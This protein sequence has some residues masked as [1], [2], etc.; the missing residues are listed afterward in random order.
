MATPPTPRTVTVGIDGNEQNP[1][2]FPDSILWKPGIGEKT[3]RIKV[4]KKVHR[5]HKGDYRLEKYP[6]TCV[7]ERKHGIRELHTNLLTPDRTR[8]MAAFRRFSTVDKPV[9]MLEG[10]LQEFWSTKEIW[11]GSPPTKV[12]VDPAEVWGELMKVCR[13]FNFS[14]WFAG[15]AD[16][17]RSRQVLGEAALRMML[18]FA[19][20]PGG[21]Q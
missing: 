18:T 20:N 15:R 7:I 16:T 3:R 8:A 11:V 6:E 17:V 5:F 13:D 12:P 19:L 10:S 9:L 4:V 14:V 21:T 1:L 2:L